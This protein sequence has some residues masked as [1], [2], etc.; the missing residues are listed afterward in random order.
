MPSKRVTV[1]CV[2][3]E[4]Y[5]HA[6]LF[7]GV[8][9]GILGDKRVM[10]LAGLYQHL[11]HTLGLEVFVFGPFTAGRIVTKNRKYV[12]NLIKNSIISLV[13]KIFN[14]LFGI[15]VVAST[16]FLTSCQQFTALD[17]RVLSD[18]PSVR[19]KALKT[20]SSL[21][22]EKKGALLP[23][24]ILAF[25]NPD[26][27]Q[28]NRAAEALV[29]IGSASVEMLK[30]TLKD[31]DVFVRINSAS[32]LG[33]IG[34]SS[35]PAVPALLEGL[36]DPHPLVREECAFALGEMGPDAFDAAQTLVKSSKEDQSEDVRATAA[37]SLKKI[38]FVAAST[39]PKKN[40]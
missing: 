29:A 34:P 16:L 40:S 26:S 14:S 3:S 6:F 5:C 24:L 11:D 32:V 1:S 15:T 37:E 8:C 22:D 9:S 33:R 39:S 21:S 28:S 17:K 25:K 27:R 36:N 12:S 10:C 7:I 23:P 20:L 35:R 18:K 30:E 13:M 31:T 38:G 2:P 19:Q 4:A